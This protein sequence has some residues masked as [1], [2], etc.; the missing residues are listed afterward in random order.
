ME[1]IPANTLHHLTMRHNQLMN[2]RN[3]F[4]LTKREQIDV[5]ITDISECIY[6]QAKGFDYSC[7]Y[8]LP[9]LYDHDVD[10]IADFLV[11][12]LERKAYDVDYDSSS[13]TLNIRW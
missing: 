11:D 5:I 7:S 4:E 1:I 10:S 6:R 3:P 9:V 13:R 12:Y 8:T 2:D